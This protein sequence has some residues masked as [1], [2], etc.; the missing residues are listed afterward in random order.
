MFGPAPQTFEAKM[1]KV[2]KEG[3]MLVRNLQEAVK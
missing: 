2:V 3:T 1:K